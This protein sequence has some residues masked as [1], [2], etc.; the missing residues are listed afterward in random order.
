M[1]T[2]TK[3]DL[4]LDVSN[5]TGMTKS[6]VKFVVESILESMSSELAKGNSIVF[7]NFGTFDVKVSKSKLGRNPRKPDELV[8][9]PERAIVK[10][11]PSKTVKQKVF[12][13]LPNIIS[14]QPAKPST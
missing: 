1:E 6:D 9:I 4:V 3:K 7:R 14:A 12:T 13:A 10:F 5:K 11:R 2:V 8:Q